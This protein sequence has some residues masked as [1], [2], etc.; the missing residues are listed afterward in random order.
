MAQKTTLTPYG[1]PGQPQSFSAK[2]PVPT[3]TWVAQ[4]PAPGTWIDRQGASGTWV[5]KKPAGGNWVKKKGM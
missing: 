5:E 4:Q 1:V 2:T 3:V